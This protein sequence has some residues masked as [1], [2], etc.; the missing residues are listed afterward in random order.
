MENAALLTPADVRVIR[1]YVH[2][3]Y[4]SLP[5]GKRADIVAT[6]VRQ[7]VNR[8]LPELPADVKDRIADRLIRQCLVGERRA[9]E[10]K[11]VL[12]ACASVALPDPAMEAL[13]VDPVLRWMQERAPGQWSGERLAARLYGRQKPQGAGED[14]SF[15]AE[16]AAA[17]EVTGEAGH[18]ADAARD[19]RRPFSAAAVP[20]LAWAAAVALLVGG[21]TAAAW[22]GEEDAAK[23]LPPPDPVATV[24]VRELQ[25]PSPDVGMPEW[26]RYQEFDAAAVIAY[27]QG[28]DSLLADEPYFSAI[29]DSARQHDVHPLLL[30]AITG[31]EQGFVPKTAKQAKRIANNPF[32]VFHSWEEFNTNIG[33]SADIAARTVSRQGSKRPEGFEPFEWLNETYAEDPNWANGVRL[34]FAKLTSLAEEGK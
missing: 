14:G 15:A 2:A 6:A 19:G 9:I 18:Y 11:D 7:T 28:R 13:I 31:Q 23:P 25:A 29:V 10:P 22:L 17:G 34:I 27:L 3:K 12:D 4:A 33:Q 1:R 30:F 21:L 26:L 32:N 16:L 20:K 5:G 24:E 8:R